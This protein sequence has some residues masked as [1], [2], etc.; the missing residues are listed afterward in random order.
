MLTINF[1]LLLAS[2]LLE[3]ELNCISASRLLVVLKEVDVIPISYRQLVEK[4]GYK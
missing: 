2:V 1:V 3:E 4:V